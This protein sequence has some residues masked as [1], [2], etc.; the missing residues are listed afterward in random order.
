[1]SI[2]QKD[3]VTIKNIL[4]PV[5]GK[6][7]SRPYPITY[8]S[9][10]SVDFGEQSQ[11]EQSP[12]EMQEK[13]RLFTNMCEWRLEKDN[14]VLVGSEDHHSRINTALQQLDGLNLLNIDIQLQTLDTVFHF[15]GSIDLRI[16]TA[17]FIDDDSPHW[18]FY[19]L[20]DQSKLEIGPGLTWSIQKNR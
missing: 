12:K 19:F 6:K 16:F 13:W 5:V 4:L 7:A 8:G 17:K 1:M 14:K 11:N 20:T 10:I 18:I 9:H 15:T 3:I 2:L